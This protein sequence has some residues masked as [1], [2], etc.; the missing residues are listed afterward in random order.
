MIEKI[1]AGGV[2]YSPKTNKFYLIHNFVKNEWKLPKGG[3]EAG[4]TL[5]QTA[6]R[7]LYEETGF[8]NLEILNPEPIYTSKYVFEE[9]GLEISKTVVYFL[10]I[11]HDLESEH[12]IQMDQENLKGDWLTFED[13]LEK[14]TFEDSIQAL[15][16]AQEI[17]TK[18]D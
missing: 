14:S 5:E 10:I 6:L 13:A 15:K 8:K 11:T 4:E 9:K 2:L 7:E 12:T 16:N 3:V 17:L 1:S 18:N